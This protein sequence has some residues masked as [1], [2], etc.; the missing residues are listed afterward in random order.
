MHALRRRLRACHPPQSPRPDIAYFGADI[1]ISEPAPYLLEADFT[2]GPVRFGDRKFDIIVAQ[3]FFEYVGGHQA[4]KLAE[5]AD[6]LA[7]GGVFIATYVNFGHRDQEIYWPYSNV[8][9]ISEFRAGLEQ[10]FHVRRAFPTSHN[11]RHSEPNRP[12]IRDVNMRLNLNIPLV[13]PRLAVEYFFIC[14]QARG[15]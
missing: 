8:R 3:G 2:E 15:C 1:A 14:D 7:P 9:P 10:H 6:I 4:A 5:I 12:V 13:S 11:W